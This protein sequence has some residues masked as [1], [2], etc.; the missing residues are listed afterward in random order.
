MFVIIALINF[1][2]IVIYTKRMIILTKI[3]VA[4]EFIF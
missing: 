3:N 1:V 4:N 2:K